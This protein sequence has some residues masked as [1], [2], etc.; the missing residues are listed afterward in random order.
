MKENYPELKCLNLEKKARR[1][2]KEFLPY[3]NKHNDMNLLRTKKYDYDIL[4]LK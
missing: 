3:T 1:L 2:C 4:L